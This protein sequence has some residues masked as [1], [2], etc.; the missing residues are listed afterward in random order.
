MER[1]AVRGG[2]WRGPWGA[3][4]ALVR[5]GTLLPKG[6]PGRGS[7]ILLH[8]LPWKLDFFP[9][10]GLP[11]GVA[12]S[13]LYRVDGDTKYTLHATFPFDFI[14]RHLCLFFVLMHESCG[15]IALFEM[16]H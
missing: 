4:S 11:V 16:M 15:L 5:Q 13:F 14:M 12:L 3:D 7:G 2:I 6:H 10:C 1:N 9:F 8:Q